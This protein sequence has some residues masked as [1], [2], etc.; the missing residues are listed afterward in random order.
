ML[1]LG[2]AFVGTALLVPSYLQVVLHETP[3]HAGLHMVP[4]GLGAALT[5][6]LA[7]ATMDKHGPGKIMLIGLPLTAAGLGIFTFGVA[8]QSAYLPTLAA[9]LAIMGLGIGCTTTPLSAAALGALA[10][11][12]VARGTTLL[13][14]NQQVSGSIGASFMAVVLT[15]LFDRS[16]NITVANRIAAVQADANKR[17]LPVDPSALPRQGL[18]PDFASN[19]VHDLSHAYATV[20]VIAVLLV[21]LT[22]VPASFL[23]KK[24]LGQT[25]LLPI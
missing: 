25:A 20:F 11:H 16:E 14:V 6:P 15:N 5:M 13:T 12:Q 22:I 1:V 8:T 10:P 4:V 17:R 18:A 9:G 2:A 3:M 19:L 24:S 21:L 23:P 7:G